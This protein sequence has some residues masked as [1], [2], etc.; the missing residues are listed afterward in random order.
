MLAGIPRA[1]LRTFEATVA[2]VV[3]YKDNKENLKVL[4]ETLRLM[5]RIFSLNWQ[6]LPEYFEDNMRLWMTEFAKLLEYTNPLLVDEDEDSEPGPIESLQTAIVENVE[7]YVVK[8]EDE[9][10]AYLPTFTQ[11]VWKLLL[12][13]RM[14]PKYDNLTTSSIKFL[15]SVSSKRL[16]SDLF[17]DQVLQ[18]II[19]H[20]VV[21]NLTARESDEELFEDNPTDFI[22]KDME[23]SDQTHG[24]DVP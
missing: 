6:D 12:E 15:T 1:P 19:Q 18:E 22:R 5:A 8:Y 2:A 11:L 7:L 13:V 21:K 17:T 16:N 9:F 20:I 23:G 4:F 10:K 3:T 24:V 14:Q